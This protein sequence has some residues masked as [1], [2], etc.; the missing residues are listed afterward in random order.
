M[1][2]EQKKMPRGENRA[3]GLV[4]TAQ[5]CTCVSRPGAAPAGQGHLAQESL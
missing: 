1:H 2:R 5:P 4:S 3:W